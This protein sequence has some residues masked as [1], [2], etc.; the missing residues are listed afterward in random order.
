ML[1][2]SAI[3]AFDSFGVYEKAFGLQ[4]LQLFLLS[5]NV[6]VVQGV[7]LGLF[8]VGH[9]APCSSAVLGTLRDFHLRVVVS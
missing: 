8:T 6:F 2:G 5:Q 4:L 3:R 1:F 9:H 7:P